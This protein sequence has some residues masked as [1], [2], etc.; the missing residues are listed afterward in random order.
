MSKRAILPSLC[1]SVL[2]LASAPLSAAEPVAKAGAKPAD[3]P[4]PDQEITVASY[5]FGNYHPGDPRNVKMK[6]ADWSEWELLKA[7]KPRFP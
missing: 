7:A 1:A 4:A 2:L 3:K 6:G 5:Y